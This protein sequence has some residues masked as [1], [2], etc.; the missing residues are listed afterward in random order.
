M[1][2]TLLLLVYLFWLAKYFF[3]LMEVFRIRLFEK[4][5]FSTF[6]NRFKWFDRICLLLKCK[7]STFYNVSCNNHFFVKSRITMINEY[8]KFLTWFI[9]TR[10]FRNFYTILFQCQ[11]MSSFTV[12]KFPRLFS[13]TYREDI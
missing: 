9:I 5:D 13:T 11:V 3:M 6:D 4:Y 1:W 2:N 7:M 10:T 12:W 8:W